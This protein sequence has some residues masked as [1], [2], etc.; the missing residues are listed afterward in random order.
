LR[1]RLGIGVGLAELFPEKPK[2]M[3]TRTYGRLL[4]EILEAEI[5]ANE[6]QANRIKRLLEQVEGDVE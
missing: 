3:W 5:Q 4:D 6:A 2:G 1:Q